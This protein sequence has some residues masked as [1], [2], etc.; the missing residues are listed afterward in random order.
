M[1]FAA[2]ALAIAGKDLRSE[3]RGREVVPALFQFAVLALVVSNF[4]F[5]IDQGSAPRIAPGVLWLAV[6]FAGLVSFGRA[7][8]VERDLGTLEAI[9]LTPAGPAAVFAG[10][11]LASGALLL[12]I[13]AVLVAGLGLFF[14]VPVLSPVLLA[15]LLLATAGMSMLGC[16]FS[17]L[18]AQTRSRELMLP[19]LALPLW[20]P[21]VVAGGSA[22]QV[23]MGGGGSGGTQALGLLLDFDILFGVAAF[24]AARY[25][26]D[27]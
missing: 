4:A 6:V 3:W 11:A 18:S 10:K 9:M 2:S 14:G 19:V 15:A 8:A 23:A 22:V 7:F 16:L 17:A 26:L 13:E 1:S 24:L 5:D 27:D 21:F 20:I 12:V 25:V